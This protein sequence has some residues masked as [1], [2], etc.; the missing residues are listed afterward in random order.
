M[1]FSLQACDHTITGAPAYDVSS[2][3]KKRLGYHRVLNVS[4]HRHDSSLKFKEFG[5]L[6]ISE[7]RYGAAVKIDVPRLSD[8]YHLQIILS[9]EC[10][11]YHNGE[12]VRLERGD[13][14]ILSP[15][16]EYAMDYSADCSKLIVKIPQSFLQH[17]AR[18]FGYLPSSSPILFTH[19]ALPFKESASLHNLLGDILE[20]KYSSTSERASLYYAKLL[21]HAI[22]STYSNDLLQTQTLPASTHRHMELIRNHILDHV[23]DDIQVDQLAQL[24]RIS[25]KSLYNLFEREVGVTPSAYVRSLKLEAIYAELTSNLSIRNITEVALKYGFSNLGRFSAQY[26][27][28]FGELP[29]E[30]LKRLS[31]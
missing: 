30:T 28:H 22:L 16:D 27:D 25:R 3:L 6:D 15:N 18:E 4:Q 1:P 5:Q 9:G 19:Q 10:G 8:I 31:R 11:W 17:A 7:H 29:S 2:F 26:R 14:L 12:N 21:S 24:C 23:T 20:Q 13:S